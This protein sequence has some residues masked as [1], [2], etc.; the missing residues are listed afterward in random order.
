M[1]IIDIAAAG[2]FALLSLALIITMNPV[3]ERRQTQS[4]IADSLATNALLS[5]L[6]A[7]DF[8]FLATSSLSQICG[9]LPT[10]NNSTTVL[11]VTVNG[12][13]CNRQSHAGYYS[14]HSELSIELPARNVKVCAWVR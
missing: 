4:V 13:S 3:D 12:V 6:G 11:D 5:Y 14:G 1:R 8:H 9:S 10:W 2:S 7:H